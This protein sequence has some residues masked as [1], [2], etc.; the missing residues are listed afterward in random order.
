[1]DD[2]NDSSTASAPD[3]PTTPQE[4]TEALQLD[5]LQVDVDYAAQWIDTMTA[6]VGQH[7]DHEPFTAQRMVAL[8][9]W[10][11][12]RKLAQ[13]KLRYRYDTNKRPE[14]LIDTST[15]EGRQEAREDLKARLQ[16]L[17]DR[18]ITRTPWKK[19]KGRKIADQMVRNAKAEVAA[20]VAQSPAPAKLKTPAEAAA[21]FIVETSKLSGI[22]DVLATPHAQVAAGLQRNGMDTAT[23]SRTMVNLRNAI[24]VHTGKRQPLIDDGI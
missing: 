1:M 15:R 6:L 22:P 11:R 3:A 4:R 16:D 8:H 2:S 13:A 18:G 10:E 21:L 17:A 24:Y 12:K 5:M 14:K 19:S 7:L 9:E 23:A 20:G